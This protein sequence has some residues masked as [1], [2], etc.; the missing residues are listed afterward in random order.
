MMNGSRAKEIFLKHIQLNRN[1]K[2]EIES[3]KKL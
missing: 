3:A 2:K 1:V